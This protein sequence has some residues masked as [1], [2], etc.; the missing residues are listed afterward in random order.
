MKGVILAGGTGSR[1]FPLTKVTN[2]HLLPVGKYPM[3]Y[4]P[5]YR[6]I[7]AGINEI[8]IVTGKEHMGSVVNL[9]GSGYEFGV[10]FTYKIQ[11]QPGGIAQALGLAEHFVNGDKCVVILGDNIFEDNINSFVS[12]FKKQ[13]KGAKVLLKE[14]SDP[15]RF[16]VAEL[17]GDKIISIEEKPKNPK[18]NYCVTGIYM[19]DSRVFDII[20]T[21]KPSGRGEL[22]ITDVNN[23]Y[24]KDG[25]LTYDILNGSWTDA[26][27]FESLKRAN[28]LSYNIELNFSDAL[29]YAA[30]TKEME[31]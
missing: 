3:I 8:L 25:T 16:G 20:K 23:A 27:T 14:V 1:L 13:E 12:S 7:E 17:K 31:D 24:I 30:A 21:L 29:E 22:E 2:K 10:E 18:S 5:I 28:E 4:Y 19:Y 11:D 26:G 6:L 9:L 15:E